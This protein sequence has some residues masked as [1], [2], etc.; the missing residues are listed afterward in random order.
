MEHFFFILNR[1]L[2]VHCNHDLYLFFRTHTSI[3]FHNLENNYIKMN[4]IFWN[5]FTIQFKGCAIS[6][7]F[8]VLFQIHIHACNHHIQRLFNIKEL[9]KTTKSWGVFSFSLLSPP[10]LYCW[11]SFIVPTGIFMYGNLKA[12]VLIKAVVMTYKSF[13]GHMGQVV[14]LEIN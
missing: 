14:S 3:C 12:L 11:S 1:K 13:V 5:S 7:S 8:K 10:F 6:S 9:I 2:E 4:K